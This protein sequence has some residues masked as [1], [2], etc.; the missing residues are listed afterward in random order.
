MK[1]ISFLF[2]LVL[3]VIQ[4]QAQE[5]YFTRNGKISFF[6]KTPLENIDA[7]NNEVFSLINTKKGEIAFA[8]LV[9][10]FKFERALMEEHFN[11]NYM[12]SGKYPKSNFSGA[13]TNL[14]SIKFSKDGSYPVEVEG[15]L[16]MHGIEKKIKGSGTFVI[17][18]GKILATSTFTIALSDFNIQI[19][20]LV[21]DKISKTVDINVECNY[22]P[23]QN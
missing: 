1:T 14:S 2:A 3:L 16:T 9:K 7:V 4:S 21:A 10:S 15:N 12:E 6:S 18:A 5:L 8:V 13:I 22:A 17:S 23:K 19:P 20:T 11:E